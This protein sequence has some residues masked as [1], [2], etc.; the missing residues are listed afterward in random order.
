LFPKFKELTEDT[1]LKK[2]RRLFFAAKKGGMN[3]F[4][5]GVRQKI[6]IGG[7]TAVNYATKFF[8]GIPGFFDQR[9]SAMGYDKKGLL[10]GLSDMLSDSA[11]HYDIDYGATNRSAFIDGKP[12]TYKGEEFFVDSNGKVYDKQTNLLMDGIIGKDAIK[13]IQERSKNVPNDEL[14]FTGGSVLDGTTGTLLNLF[15]LIKSGT[16]VNKSL[17][18]DKRL[19]KKLAGKVGMG[20]ASFTSG[21]VDNVEDI[22]SQLMATGMS[23]KEAMNIAV[24]AGQA[25]ST[26]DGVFSGI[27]GSNEKL[28]TGF[29]GIKDQIKNLA[30][31]KGKDFTRKQFQQKSVDLLKENAKELFIE[32][33]QFIFQKR[34]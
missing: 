1:D 11:E 18:L 28:L 31:N 34:L 5:E 6:R 19:G 2:R 10:A 26:L 25:I 22:R 24:N 21:V 15:A 7:G 33:L 14:Q 13:E 16:K 23:E 9:L 4:E 20:L 17:G 3:E 32:E 12:V 8:A 30:I 27:A 29:Q